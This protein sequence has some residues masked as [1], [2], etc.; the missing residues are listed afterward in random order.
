MAILVK[1]LHEDIRSKLKKHAGGFVSPEDIDTAINDAA[2]DVLAL[3]VKNY[4]ENRLE[5]TAEQD[6]LLNFPL[7]GGPVYTLPLDI[8]SLVAVFDG[9]AEGDILNAFD[10][11]N[12]RNSLILAPSS[13]KPIATVYNLASSPKIEILPTS[14]ANSIK[15]WKNP[16][17]CV[18]AYTAPLGVITYSAGGSI[19]LNFPL[20]Y[21]TDIVA[22]ALVYLTPS[23]KNVEAAQ[24]E[25]QIK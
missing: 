24:L 4:K 11:N 5:R 7:T 2:L 19:D 9:N 17:K 8:F 13:L 12:R 1:D 6:L 10:F 22:R 20:S 15:Y 14:G 25:T 18:F 23:A 21:K 16:T 3:I